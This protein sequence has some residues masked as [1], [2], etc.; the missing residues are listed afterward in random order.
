MN[1]GTVLP[2][3]LQENDIS[4]GSKWDLTTPIVVLFNCIEDCKLFSES[5]EDLFA[6]K[7]ILLSAYVSIEDTRFFNLPCYICRD[8]TTGAKNWSN[9][10]LFFTKEAANIKHHTT[11]SVKLNDEALNYILQMITSFA[12]QQGGRCAITTSEQSLRIKGSHS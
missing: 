8:K 5:E 2:K 9:S 3:Q 6:E 7:S 4:L 11:G 1:Y 12:P 10:K